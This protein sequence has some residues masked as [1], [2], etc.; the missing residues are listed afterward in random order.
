MF[1][2]YW[3]QLLPFHCWTFLPQKISLLPLP[4]LPSTSPLRIVWYCFC[5]F[6]NT[7]FNLFLSTVCV[8]RVTEFDKLNFSTVILTMLLLRMVL[9]LIKASLAISLRH[10]ISFWGIPLLINQN[11]QIFICFYPFNFHT[12]YLNGVW[13]FCLRS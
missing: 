7:A 11:S 8:R 10:I 13:V 9:Y 12:F 3:R 1:Y 2:L 6:L 5:L 4:R